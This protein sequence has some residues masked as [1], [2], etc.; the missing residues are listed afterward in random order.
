MINYWLPG[1]GSVHLFWERFA[2][3][4]RPVTFKT[5]INHAMLTGLV[6]SREMATFWRHNRIE[7]PRFVALLLAVS[8]VSGFRTFE[9]SHFWR[10]FVTFWR[11]SPIVRPQFGCRLWDRF[12]SISEVGDLR[13]C[14]ISHFWR[15]FV[16]F[17]RHYPIVRPRFGSRLWDRFWAISE[18]GDLRI[19]EISHFWRF[20]VT[21]WRHYL[22]VGPRFRLRMVCFW[23]GYVSPPQNQDRWTDTHPG[24]H[25]RV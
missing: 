10:F 6:A 19:C 13:I 23:S 17:W 25:L 14:V 22:I 3:R 8:E 16:T 5:G 18:V 1:G 9:I 24:G 12:G 15:C 2:F 11:H 20:F 21:F 4:G 7:V